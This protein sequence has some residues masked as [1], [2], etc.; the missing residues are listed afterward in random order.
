[1]TLLQ[2]LSIRTSLLCIRNELTSLY[3]DIKSNVSRVNIFP[4]YYDI[5]GLISTL[6]RMPN[7][8]SNIFI[9]V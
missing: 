8:R 5:I 7:N 2:I 9:K 1:M 3:S 6:D 4:V